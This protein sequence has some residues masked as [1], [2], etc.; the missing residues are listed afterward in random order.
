MLHW[1][2]AAYYQAG[3]KR[4]YPYGYPEYPGMTWGDNVNTYILQ[5]LLKMLPYN[6]DI[7]VRNTDTNIEFSLLSNLC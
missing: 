1:Q 4:E 3:Y 6:K 2:T 5:N 7:V